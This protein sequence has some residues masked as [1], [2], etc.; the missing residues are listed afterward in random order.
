MTPPP[1]AARPAPSRGSNPEPNSARRSGQAATRRACRAPVGGTVVPRRDPAAMAPADRLDELCALLAVGYRRLLLN[2][3]N[4]LAESA[5]PEAP[6]NS[7]DT[8]REANST[9][10]VA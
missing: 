2:R 3:Q 1:K 7:V 5:A 9:E 8:H 4:G 10:E 6:C